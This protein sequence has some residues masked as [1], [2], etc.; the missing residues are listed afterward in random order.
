M[1]SPCTYDFTLG[2]RS[3][4][5]VVRKKTRHSSR[6]GQPRTRDVSKFIQSALVDHPSTSDPL[7]SPSRP[8]KDK[9]NLAKRAAPSGVNSSSRKKAKKGNFIFPS[10]L[11]TNCFSN[12]IGRTEIISCT[13]LCSLFNNS[14]NRMYPSPGSH[15]WNQLF[16]E[17]KWPG[18]DEGEENFESSDIESY[19]DNDPRD[20]AH[21]D[22]AD[23]VTDSDGAATDRVVEGTVD[24]ANKWRRTMDLLHTSTLR[25]QSDVVS[26]IHVR[27]CMYIIIIHC[28]ADCTLSRV[29]RCCV[30]GLVLLTC[31]CTL[32]LC[33]DTNN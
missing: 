22:S 31:T 17:V 4:F 7:A 12:R 19:S 30:E 3:D 5:Q 25:Q 24:R 32:G 26:V 21:L 15:D 20:V 10:S 9:Q 8:S 33:V 1:V 13:E 6:K 16:S 27:T 28:T 23:I 29:V 18:L 2:L 11:I 14:Y